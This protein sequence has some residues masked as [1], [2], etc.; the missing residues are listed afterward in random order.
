MGTST[1]QMCIFIKAVCSSVNHSSSPQIELRKRKLCST[2]SR[3]KSRTKSYISETLLSLTFGALVHSSTH[4]HSVSQSSSISTKNLSSLNLQ[5]ETQQSIP[6][7]KDVCEC[8]PSIDLIGQASRD[9]LDSTQSNPG[10][11]NI[12][13]PLPL[14]SILRI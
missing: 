14:R 11:N 6:L 2:F 8:F 10:K 1:Q 9:S 13:L 7:F 12:P 3:P 4:S 5:Q